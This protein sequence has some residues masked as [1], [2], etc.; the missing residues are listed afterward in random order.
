M[1]YDMLFLMLSDWPLL[2]GQSLIDLSSVPSRE[3]HFVRGAPFVFG[4]S[5]LD[6]KECLLRKVISFRSFDTAARR[7]A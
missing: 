6:S 1:I 5:N 2:Q 3:V 4:P 7:R